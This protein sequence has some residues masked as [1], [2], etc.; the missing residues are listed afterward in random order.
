MLH[1]SGSCRSGGTR[2]LLVTYFVAKATKCAPVAQLDRASAC[3]AEGH[4]FKS[5]RVYQGK[6]PN[7][8]VGI[9][10]WLNKV[11]ANNELPSEKR[12]TTTRFIPFGLVETEFGYTGSAIV[13]ETVNEKGK[14]IRRMGNVLPTISMRELAD[15]QRAE[16]SPS[17]EA[18]DVIDD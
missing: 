14:V 18:T 7:V 11:M 1:L 16:R 17:A 4:R 2:H 3:G 5:C 13:A 12:K 10:L 15:K 8:C 9:F 6:I